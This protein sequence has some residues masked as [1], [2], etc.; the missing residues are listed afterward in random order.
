MVGYRNTSV[1]AKKAA[2]VEQKMNSRAH[3][4]F[5][6][7]NGSDITTWMWHS[8]NIKN[9]NPRATFF[10]ITRSL[11]NLKLHIIRLAQRHWNCT[12]SH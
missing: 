2:E 10:K 4:E 9:T 5:Y 1:L 6:I 8:F 3:G 7:H 12:A 11:L